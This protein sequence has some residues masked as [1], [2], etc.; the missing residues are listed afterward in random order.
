[1]ANLIL[2]PTH[3]RKAAMRRRAR[4]AKRS[5]TYPRKGVTPNA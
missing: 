1:M 3:R 2:F 4:R 5:V